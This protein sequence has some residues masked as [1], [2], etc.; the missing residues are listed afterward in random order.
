[1][2]RQSRRKEAPGTRGARNE[3]VCCLDLLRQGFV[4][5]RNTSPHGV[6]DLLVLK[7][8][9]VVRV[10]VRSEVG[11]AGIRS[12]DLLAVVTSEGLLRYR[13]KNRKVARLLEECKI[14][15]QVKSSRLK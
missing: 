12:N 9:Q 10:Q 6:C 15:R 2:G 7:R 4:V 5:Y 14:I 3:L 13:A 11:R 1:M 8:G